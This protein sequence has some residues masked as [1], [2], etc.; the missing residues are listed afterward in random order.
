MPIFV[1]LVSSI[2]FAEAYAWDALRPVSDFAKQID[3]PIK[4][5]VFLL[6]LSIFAVSVLAYRKAPSKRMLLVAAAFFLFSLK[7][8]VKL[9]DLF[10]SPGNFLSDS[11]ENVFELGILISLLI[12]L[13]HSGSF[14]GSNKK[15]Q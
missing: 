3:L 15:S 7:W 14:N 13:F 4:V 8:L 12:A 9:V 11:S 1:L 10:Y 2:V 6:A 5:I